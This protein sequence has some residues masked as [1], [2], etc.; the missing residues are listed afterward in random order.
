MKENQVENKGME[1]VVCRLSEEEQKREEVLRGILKIRNL[2]NTIMQEPFFRILSIKA[3][4]SKDEKL[5]MTVHIFN[6]KAYE[7]VFDS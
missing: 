4:K 5:E 7:Q 6:K 2:A 3:Q 1:E